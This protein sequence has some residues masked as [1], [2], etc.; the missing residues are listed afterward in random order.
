MSSLR[1]TSLRLLAVVLSVALVASGCSG[2]DKEAKDGPAPVSASAVETLVSTGANQLAAGEVE[3][4][5][6]TFASVLTLDPSNLLAHYNLGLIA[7]QDGDTATAIKEYD[8]AL[9]TDPAYG[10]ALF[11]KAILLEKTDLEEAVALYQLAAEA[12]PEFAPTQ[13]RL[14]F[15]LVHLGRVEEGEKHLARGLKLDPSMKDVVAPDY[16]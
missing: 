12:Q 4:A 5:R 16:D 13:M 7:Q 14:G 10:P 3:A 15:A 2:D 8:A 6:G 1:S 11:N 9:A